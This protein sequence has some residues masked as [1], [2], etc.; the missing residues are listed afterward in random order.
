MALDRG[1]KI[2]YF[3]NAINLQIRRYGI[4]FAPYMQLSC[5]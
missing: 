4:F 2:L 5:I 3:L 1:K